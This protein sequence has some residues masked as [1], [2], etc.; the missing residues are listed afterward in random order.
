MYEKKEIKEILDKTDIVDLIKDYLPGLKKMGSNYKT[1]CPFHSEKTPSFTV[2]QNKQMFFC[3]GC[4]TG[5]DA[6]AFLMKIENITFGEAIKKLAARA[7]VTLEENYIKNLSA[8]EMEKIN[9]KK[10]LSLA[11]S[12]Y[13]DLIKSAEGKEALNYLYQRGFK[14][15]TLR[16]FS[17]GFC[18]KDGYSLLENLKKHAIKNNELRAAGLITTREDGH[19]SEIF[20][21]RIMF[22]IRN[23]NGDI[24]GFGGRILESGMPK[25]LNSPENMLFSKRKVLYGL[26]ESLPS[27]RK[28]KK[29]II[30]EGY[31]DV[32]MMHQY[33]MTITVSP[34][35]TSLTHDQCNILKRYSDEAWLIFD[36]DEA[37]IKAAIKAADTM[38]ESGLYPKI[39]LLPDN[40]D[41]D[42]FIKENGIES[43]TK[44]I[45]NAKDLIDFKIDLIKKK[46]KQISPNEKSSVITY[47]MESVE[48]QKDEIIKN[49]WIKKISQN[50][51]IP[52]NTL[53]KYKSKQKEKSGEENAF[54]EFTEKIPNIE[55]DLIKILLK[56]PEIV[57][58]LKDLQSKHFSSNFAKIIFSEIV[59]SASKE[60]LLNQLTD[61]YPDYSKLIMSLY[62]QEDHSPSGNLNDI[63]QIKQLI[64]MAYNKK[65][66]QN[67]KKRIADLTKEE[68]DRF[69]E[70]SKI[71]K[72]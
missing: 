47:L 3:F 13:R 6:I 8:S 17:V 68:L 52:E 64:L 15:E 44:L 2:N 43:M 16:N 12:F 46:K 31:M 30:V 69:N 1:L 25:Y 49:E 10:T 4:G 42:E 7:G 27:I 28:L 40:K 22:P 39:V 61:K 37:G 20:R 11:N 56:K 72:K 14:D 35:G 50:F 36:P 23:F 66:W 60:N 59:N 21:N 19:I 32:L 41:P 26:Y 63:E 9:I 24:I 54:D 58:Y 53:F 34:L 70:L 5:G 38:E 62:I 67:L 33:G 57:E 45:E 48:K 65:E 29:A 51:S 55:K 71:I 18:G